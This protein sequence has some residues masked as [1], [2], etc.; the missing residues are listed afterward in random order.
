MLARD[1]LRV[2]LRERSLRDLAPQPAAREQRRVGAALGVGDHDAEAPV[3]KLIRR[4][5]EVVAH[6]LE[7]RLEQEP[8]SGGR[9][10]CNRFQL[11]LGEPADHVV[12]ELGSRQ[13]RDGDAGGGCRRPQLV[14][15]LGEVGHVGDEVRPDMRSCD[16][17]RG[18]VVRGK[19]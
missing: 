3:A 2:H 9:S 7:R 4:R 10:L 16:D 17:G 15:S 14:D 8:A 6:A 19:P 13:K 1:R 5:V 18:G 12:P 11:A